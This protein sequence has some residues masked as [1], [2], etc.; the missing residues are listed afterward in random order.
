MN[1]KSI[2]RTPLTPEE[3]TSFEEI[4]S[5]W[6]W[7]PGEDCDGVISE[8]LTAFWKRHDLEEISNPVNWLL[9]AA[10]LIRRH[11][12]KVWTREVQRNNAIYEER[13]RSA[14]ATE[15]SRSS[16]NTNSPDCNESRNRDSLT[17]TV[18][19]VVQMLKQDERDA[20]QVCVMYDELPISE[21]AKKLG[22]P[23]STLKSKVCRTLQ[24]LKR[25][26]RHIIE[27][28]NLNR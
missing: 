26:L 19:K 16:S 8:A 1:P 24:K 2:K 5:G 4:V 17:R 10:K 28:K 14:S 7:F 20:I 12:R 15:K 23:R 18:Q 22:V 11:Q 3:L 25:D 6:C 9:R 13:V 27:P 21:A